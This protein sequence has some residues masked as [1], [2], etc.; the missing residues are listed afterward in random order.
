MR[1]RQR[2]RVGGQSK[3]SVPAHHGK[4]KSDLKLLAVK[5]A[6]KISDRRWKWIPNDQRDCDPGDP[7]LAP[8]KE[9]DPAVQRG[10][11]R[12]PEEA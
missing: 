10:R 5:I 11:L 8:A 2:D 12:G 1:P 9:C 3:R 4:R 6:E 7:D